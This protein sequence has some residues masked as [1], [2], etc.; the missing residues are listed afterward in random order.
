MRF[1][2]GPR[3][4]RV[5]G[6]CAAA[7]GLAGCE[8]LMVEPAPAPVGLALALAPTAPGHAVAPASANRIRVQVQE[9]GAVLLDSIQDFDPEAE[10]VLLPVRF[11]GDARNALVRVEISEDWR[12]LLRGTATILLEQRRVVDA[13]VRLFGAGVG[14]LTPATALASGV[15]H[16]CATAAEQGLFCWGNNDEGQLGTGKF[17]PSPLAEAIEGSG[18]FYALG[19]G[20]LTSCGLAFEGAA[21]CWGDN[22]FGSLG[23]GGS[24]AR[25]AQP[26][27]VAFEGNFA[28][29][30]VG[31]LHACGLTPDGAAYCWG[32]NGF[33]QL[34]DG[35][36]TDRSSPVRVAAEVAFREIS[37]G[38]LHTC[39][40]T[41]QGL[42]LCWG[43]NEFGQLGDG[44]VADRASPAPI[45]DQR[46]FSTISAGGLHTCAATEA[47]EAFCWGF[48]DF[49]QLGDGSNQQSA[50]PVS[51]GALRFTA[52]SAGG[53]HSCGLTD[54]GDAWCW[55]YNRSGALG[56]DTLEDSAAPVQV[57]GSL[58]FARISSG[59]HHTCASVEQSGRVVCW[60]FNRFGQLGDGTRINRAE[61]ADVLQGDPFFTQPSIPGNSENNRESALPLRRFPG[62]GASR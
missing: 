1:M 21:F 26:V 47:G 34:G 31:G 4:A 25:S 52:L 43:L 58:N 22:E 18:G 23:S 6:I 50:L 9:E 42:T 48:N 57:T 45:A 38:Y 62:S 40:I 13:E 2:H 55:G 11:T 32:F 3:T 7:L 60:G 10:E 61:P 44:G 30:T 35:T 15:Y 54:S 39:G 5:I 19:A 17:T 41:T 27:P 24:P 12:P 14:P 53:L 20:F 16:S 36:T 51:V 33:G 28:T 59:L 8:Q 56:D 37:A 49:G 29:L 46:F